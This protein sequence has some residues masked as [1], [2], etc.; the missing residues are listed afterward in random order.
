[1]GIAINTNMSRGERRIYGARHINA[2][3]QALLDLGK[4]GIS[5]EKIYARSDTPEGIRLMRH[6]GLTEVPSTTDKRNFYLDVAE[7]GIPMIM[8]YKIALP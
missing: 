8:E 6:M 1:M 4:R 7:S 2:L 3:R 5:I